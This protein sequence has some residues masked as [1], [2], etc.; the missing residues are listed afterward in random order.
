[1]RLVSLLIVVL[2]A[3]ALRAQGVLTWHNDA[4]RSGQNLNETLLTPSNVN[5]TGFGLLSKL[6]LDGAVD[7]QP[8]YVPGLPVNG[9]LH[10]V[11]YVATENDTLYAIDADTGTILWSQSFLLGESVSDSDNGCG[12]VGPEVGITSTPV[13]DLTQ[14]PNGTIY[15]VAMTKVSSTV[16]H[17]RLHAVDLVEGTEQSGWPIVISV[18]NYPSSGPNSVGGVLPF[19]PQKYKERAGLSIS[20]GVIYTTWASNCDD[21]PYNGWVIGYNETTQAQTVLNLTPNGE[22]GAIW[23]SGAGPA[24]DAG[25]NLYFLMAN[26]YFDGTLNAYG[27]PADGDYGNA[28]MNLSTTPSLAVADYFTSD[29]SPVES[30]AQNDDDLGSGGAM[31]LPVLNDAMGNPHE[32]AVGAGKDG[33]AYVVDRNN[34]GKY[35]MSSNVVY[36]HFALGGAVFSS[37]AWFNNTL[38]YGASGQQI[39]G[40]AYSDGSFG[41]ASEA[42]SVSAGFGS[43]GAT[44]SISA[45]GAADGIVWAVTSNSSPAVLYGFNASNLNELYDSTQ[46]AGSRDSFGN[47]GHFPTPTAFGGKVYVPTTTGVAIFGLLNCTYTVTPNTPSSPTT[48]SISVTTG[49]GCAWSVSNASNFITITSGSS[50]TGSGTV[51]FS[52]TTYDGAARTGI[53]YVAGEV[54]AINQTGSNTLSVPSGPSPANGSEGASINPVLSW[55]AASGAT[56]YTVYFGTSP[57]PPQVT[58]TS[59]TSYAPGKLD[60]GITYYWMVVANNAGTSNSSPV[61]SFITSNVNVASLTPSMGAGAGQTIAFSFTDTAGASDIQAAGIVINTSFSAVNACFLY[62][63]NGTNLLYLLTNSGSVPAGMVI[64]SSGTLSNSQCSVNVGSSSVTLSGDTLRLNLALT[65]AP[66]FVGLNNVYMYAQN[67]TVNS[68]WNLEGTFAVTTAAA[69]SIGVYRSGAWYVD[70]NHDFQYDAGDSSYGF[71][72][73]LTGASPVI[74]PWHTSAPSWLGVY[75]SATWYVDTNGTG[76][77][78]SGDQSYSFGFPGAYPV[79][80]D[81]THSGVLRIGAFLNGV[82]YVDTN[83]DHVFDAGDQTLSYGIQGDYPVLGDWGH[84]GTRKIGVYRGNGVWVVDANADNVFDAGDQYFFFGFTGAIPV[85]GDWTG[86]GV[87]KIGVFDPTTGNW[88]L[89]LNANG[90]FDPGEGPFQFGQ[91]GDQPAVICPSVE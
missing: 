3:P 35:N 64:G 29:N 22:D 2:S 67:T 18:T 74:G 7:A 4:A 45:N 88:Y 25:G 23:M 91:A 11:L 85:V 40:Y 66:G 17:Q 51:D 47:T 14:G 33:T 61:W 71:G 65:F 10:N 60:P 37:P 12:Q 54:I 83:N 44:P 24:V 32:L 30:G 42:T 68:T 20:N 13:I 6:T 26:G 80:G 50:G 34:M 76:A 15:F 52:V 63:S 1:M 38:Y 87:D 57:T 21:G 82:W 41:A 5:S 62:F 49:A 90:N 16:Y 55:T 73:G 72:L 77:Y 75:D 79:V 8:L 36:Q 48:G 78:T 53:L 69:C 86:N 70:T 43:N 39:K 9:A 81:W 27:F 28:F 19:T 58:T 31:L 46:A 59:S 84:T 56:S 89:D